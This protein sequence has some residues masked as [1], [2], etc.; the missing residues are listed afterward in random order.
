MRVM[1]TAA[2]AVGVVRWV[3]SAGEVRRVHADGRQRVTRQP[4]RSIIMQRVR[5]VL[6]RM[7]R[8]TTNTRHGGQRRVW[9]RGRLM[10]SLRDVSGQ[11]QLLIDHHIELHALGLDRRRRCLRRSRSATGRGRR[12]RRSGAGRC[13]GSR[14][15]G[16]FLLLCSRYSRRLRFRFRFR[17]SSTVLGISR[18]GGGRRWRQSSAAES[19]A[20]CAINLFGAGCHERGIDLQLSEQISHVLAGCWATSGRTTGRCGAG[21]RGGGGGGGGRGDGRSARCRRFGRWCGGHRR[22]GD[23]LQRFGRSQSFG[24]ITR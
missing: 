7:Q 12:A 1:R 4:T 6:G 19:L 16:H 22:D 8:V 10:V 17:G 23:G 20:S 2:A 15:V 5:I 13:G 3:S 11:C 14:W 18:G 24:W 21:S 9:W